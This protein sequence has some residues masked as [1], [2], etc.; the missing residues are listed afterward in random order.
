MCCLF[1]NTFQR[2]KTRMDKGQMGFVLGGWWG[3]VN[4]TLVDLMWTEVRK[5]CLSTWIS[6]LRKV[7]WEG[8]LVQINWVEA[9]KEKEKR[10]MAISP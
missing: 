10:I 9:L 4:L 6:V 3:E 7:T 2:M 1:E 5:P 8:E